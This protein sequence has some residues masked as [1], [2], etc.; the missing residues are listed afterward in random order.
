MSQSEGVAFRLLQRSRQG[1]QVFRSVGEGAVFGLQGAAL[2]VMVMKPAGTG[3]QGPGGHRRPL[4]T[5]PGGLPVPPV[6]DVHPP[7]FH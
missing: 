2:R 7:S 5:R 4:G 1:S 3:F 6:S